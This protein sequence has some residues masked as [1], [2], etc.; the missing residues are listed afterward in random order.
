MPLGTDYAGQSCS[1]ARTLEIVGERWTLLI[2]RDLFFGV[3][4]FTDLQRHLDIPRAVLAARLTTLVDH[5]LVERRPYRAGRDELT[6][7]T[8]GEELWPAVHALLQWG[9]R[10]CSPAGPRRVF[11]HAACG[12]DLTP[13]GR[14]AA[15]EVTPAP[16]AVEMRPGPGAG[17]P[18]RQDA[19]SI[20][21]REPRRLLEPLPTG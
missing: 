7:T 6:L 13:A 16:G 10:H 21:L 5:G 11:A 1:L 4:R 8:A 19:V 9:E 12:T 2:V 14:C 17:P 20:A 3:R 15:C 18:Q